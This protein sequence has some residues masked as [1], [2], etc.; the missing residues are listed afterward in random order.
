MVG[1][2]ADCAQ[3][4]ACSLHGK[5]R[6][7][8]A[9]AERVAGWQA[10]A[11]GLGDEATGTVC[12]ARTHADC[13]KSEACTAEGRCRVWRGQCITRELYR[14]RRLELDNELGPL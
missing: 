14:A 9:L 7:V 2:R 5:C 6:P 13:R 11:L 1:S 8:S 12:G 10:P 3:S 4:L